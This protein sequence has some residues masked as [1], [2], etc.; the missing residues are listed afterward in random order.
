MATALFQAGQLPADELE[1]AIDEELTALRPRAVEKFPL[2]ELVPADA[3]FPLIGY[4]LTGS[5]LV[6][7]MLESA[8]EDKPGTRV[9]AELSGADMERNQIAGIAA[10]KNEARVTLTG[11]ADAP[12]MVA[13]VISPLAAAGIQVD[14]IV[15]AATEGQGAS[16][17]N[18]TVG[19]ASLLSLA[20]GVFFFDSLRASGN[21]D[22]R[23]AAHAALR[24]TRR[25]R[26]ADSRRGHACALDRRRGRLVLRV[27][28]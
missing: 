24:A 15:H 5:S 14:M 23:A 18:F 22:A 8:F 12:G 28:R 26:G 4:H 2:A 20:F 1:K 17:L 3:V 13:Q 9:V 7:A 27:A 21:A 11:I 6:A 10:D 16:D 19:R 25:A